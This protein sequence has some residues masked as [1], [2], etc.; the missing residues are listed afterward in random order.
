MRWF[1]SGIYLLAGGWV[2]WRWGMG[3]PAGWIER[4]GVLWLCA[5]MI[6]QHLPRTT[7]RSYEGAQREGR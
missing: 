3:E 1:W 2:L 5:L 7:A 4:S 6:E